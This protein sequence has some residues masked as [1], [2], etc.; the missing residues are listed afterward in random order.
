MLGIGK[1]Q[2][3]VDT[4]IFKSDVII[5]VSNNDG[6]YEFKVDLGDTPVPGYEVIEVKQEGNDTLIGRG[7]IEVLPGKEITVRIHFID[8]DHFE[9]E[10]KVPMLGKVKL[11]DGHRIA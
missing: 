10:L 9:G 2:A 5:E 6:E 11:K 3:R 4:L 1:W 7:T 8:N